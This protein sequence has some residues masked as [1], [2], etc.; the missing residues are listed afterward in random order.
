MFLG[1]AATATTDSS[2]LATS[3]PLLAN[4][5]P[6]RFTATASTD[7]VSTVATYTFDNH[8]DVTML[9]AVGRAKANARVGARYRRP[10]SVTVH[11]ATGHPIEGATVNFAVAP[12]ESGAAATFAGGSSQTTAMTDANGR[13]S[14]PRL[15]ANKTAGS[16]TATASTGDET[17]RYRLTNVPGA[18][19]S[20][21]AGAAS[22]ES[23]VVQ[24]RF[25][26]PLAVT[27]TDQYGNPVVGQVVVFT[28]PAHGPSGH[29]AKRSRRTRVATNRNG[30]AVAPPLTANRKAGGFAVTARVEGSAPRAAFALINTG[31][32]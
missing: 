19:A 21:A 32:A 26:V 3:P 8:A 24:T 4:G 9:A 22:G 20:I 12:A 14:S 16:F 29:F 25:A 18:P 7:G 13:A 27:V 15:V 11:D 28:T 1:G 5:T 2:G 31:R 6:G 30:V 10:L 23:T 17:L